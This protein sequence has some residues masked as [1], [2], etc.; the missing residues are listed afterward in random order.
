MCFLIKGW[1][2][3][4]ENTVLVIFKLLVYIV[5]QLTSR[6]FGDCFLRIRQLTWSHE[7]TLSRN[8]YFCKEHLLEGYFV[9][10]N[11]RKSE[12]QRSVSDSNFF[13]IHNRTIFIKLMME[14]R[15]T[16]YWKA[17]GNVNLLLNGKFGE[18]KEKHSNWN[19]LW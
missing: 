5:T 9:I 15:T 8:L 12:Q 13:A 1:G 17:F 19:V 10:F 6:N 4:G 18:G 16:V 3:G 11:H 2:G 14:R 7:I